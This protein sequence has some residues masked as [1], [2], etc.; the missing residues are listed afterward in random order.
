[1]EAMLIRRIASEAV[2]SAM[3]PGG[4]LIVNDQGV[5]VAA[6][7]SGHAVDLGDTDASAAHRR[8]LHGKDPACPAF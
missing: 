3:Q 2:T 4:V 5:A 7:V 6:K 8:R 1:M